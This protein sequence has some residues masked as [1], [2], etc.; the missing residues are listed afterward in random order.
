MRVISILVS[1][2]LVHIPNEKPIYCIIIVP[3][4]LSKDGGEVLWVFSEFLVVEPATVLPH[5]VVAPAHHTAVHLVCRWN[6]KSSWGPSYAVVWGEM[7]KKI[8]KITEHK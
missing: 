3:H 6:N 1:Q 2:K 8:N 7:E 4:L 5:D